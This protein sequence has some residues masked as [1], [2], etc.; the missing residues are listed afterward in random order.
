[1]VL[2]ADCFVSSFEPW[3]AEAAVKVL[4]AMGYRVVIPRESVCCG[5]TAIS[6]GVLQHARQQVEGAAGHLARAVEESDAIAVVVLEPSCLSAIQ[7]EWLELR[8]DLDPTMG[9]KLAALS[10]SL[11][12]FLLDKSGKHPRE[13]RFQGSAVPHVVHPHCHAKVSRE[14]IGDAMDLLGFEHVRVLDNGCC[15][16][17]GSFGYMKQTEAI[18]RTIAEQSLGTFLKQ[19]CDAVVVAPGTS[20]RH[21]IHDCFGRKAYHPA[22]IVARSLAL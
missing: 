3:I 21:Q 11:E 7:E 17:A 2:F 20:C 15:G 9:E 1:V 13:P 10:C 4:E 8:T 12:R 22:E 18:S 14:E 16:M 19:E 5:R 6:A